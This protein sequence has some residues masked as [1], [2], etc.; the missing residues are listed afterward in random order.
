MSTLQDLSSKFGTLAAQLIATAG[1][2]VP[3]F[4][5]G[6]EDILS[7]RAENS[8]TTQS[9]ID[10]LIRSG[11]AVQQPH[12]DSCDLAVNQALASMTTINNGMPGS[13][14]K[15]LVLAQTDNSN[16]IGMALP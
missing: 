4:M 15:P 10:D 1:N 14:T 5:G 8:E 7:D 9:H 12:I 16:K 6:D 13:M 2:L 11:T 3:P